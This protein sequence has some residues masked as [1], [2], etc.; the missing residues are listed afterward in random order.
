MAASNEDR[1]GHPR[2]LFPLESSAPIFRVRKA[3][4]D[5][6]IK[7]L[8]GLSS[9]EPNNRSGEV[10]AARKFFAL[11]RGVWRWHDKL[12]EEILDEISRQHHM[13]PAMYR[14][15]ER[16]RGHASPE[17]RARVRTRKLIGSSAPFVIARSHSAFTR[18]FDALW[19]RSN[20]VLCR[21]PGL[22]R[23]ARNDG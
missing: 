10:D 6:V 19:R 2:R 5:E 7:V 12:A 11:C 3:W 18:V 16:E 22:L 1:S 17:S 15:G 20:P 13:L 14:G 4:T 8:Y 23:F 21:I 9:I